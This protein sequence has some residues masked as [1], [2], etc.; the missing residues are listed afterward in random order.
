[1]VTQE[2]IQK[3]LEEMDS[4]Q[5]LV[6][7]DTEEQMGEDQPK[8]SYEAEGNLQ[9]EQEPEVDLVAQAR[10]EQR[11]AD[12]RYYTLQGEYKRLKE[13][14]EELRQ[15]SKSAPPMQQAAVINADDL[16]KDPDYQLLEEQWGESAAQAM[17]NM[18]QKMVQPVREDLQYT[19]ATAGQFAEQAAQIRQERFYAQLSGVVPDWQEINANAGDFYN[20]VEPFTGH[21][22][23]ALIRHYGEQGDVQ[24][25][26]KILNDARATLPKRQAA[27]A[28]PVKS[29]NP[30]EKMLEPERTGRGMAPPSNSD[31]RIF[32]RAEVERIK[33]DYMDFQTGRLK[34]NP[35]KIQ[36]RLD[37]VKLALAED[38]VR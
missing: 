13:E 4:D 2:Q 29:N 34:A 15:M 35:E 37:E 16:A 5:P 27:T 18:A 20:Q 19:K 7:A 17:F 38:R 23:D 10:E 11:K 28:I 14:A 32:S 8:T 30:L 9:Q 21:T 25:V 33:S 26:A 6:E 12:A 22:Y 36:A 1:M 24:R 3:R 31:N